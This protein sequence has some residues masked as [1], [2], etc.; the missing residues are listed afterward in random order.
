VQKQTIRTLLWHASLS[1]CIASAFFVGE[2]VTILTGSKI[3]GTYLKSNEEEIK[4]H[5]NKFK[6]E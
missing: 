2:G 6:E 1:L 3:D 4:K 5:F